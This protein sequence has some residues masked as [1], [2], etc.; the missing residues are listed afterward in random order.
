MLLVLQHQCY[1]A[2]SPLFGWQHRCLNFWMTLRL[3][4][5]QQW[6][7]LYQDLCCNQIIF[8]FF[9]RDDFCIAFGYRRKLKTMWSRRHECVCV[10]RS[11]WPR[12]LSRRSTAARR[13]GIV[14]SNPT[15]GMGVC[16]L[17]VLCLLSGGGLCDELIT[18]P[19]ESYGLWSVVVCDLET[20]WIRR[21]WPTGDCR[22]KNKQTNM[23]VCFNK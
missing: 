15:A 10:C 20:S 14:G 21:P 19:E 1:C 5:T 23:H 12:V 22:A 11:Q 8:P 6:N 9:V 18:R 7:T 17:W 16:L 2:V 13:A 3:R 4:V